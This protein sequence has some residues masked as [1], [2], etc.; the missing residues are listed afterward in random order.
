MPVPAVCGDARRAGPSR[1]CSE[2]MRRDGSAPIVHGCD[3]TSSECTSSELVLVVSDV[4]LMRDGSF[5]IAE[6]VEF[7]LPST[8][9]SSPG[10]PDQEGERP[11]PSSKLGFDSRSLGLGVHHNEGLGAV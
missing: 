7:G 6:S 2:Y 3:C 1:L 4:E 11:T 10:I 8:D 9:E 5:L